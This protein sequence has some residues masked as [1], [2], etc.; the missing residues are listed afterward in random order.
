MSASGRIAQYVNISS[1][2]FFGN[3][4]QSKVYVFTSVGVLGTMRYQ[5]IIGDDHVEATGGS[6]KA[7]KVTVEWNVTRSAT[8]KIEPVIIEKYQKGPR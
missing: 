5:G 3:T 7:T 1:W 6:K 4:C 2:M 8:A